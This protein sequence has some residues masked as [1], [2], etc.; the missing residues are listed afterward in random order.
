MQA[1]DSV[2][3]GWMQAVDSLCRDGMD[4]GSRLSM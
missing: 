4:A 3:M 1:V 2:G